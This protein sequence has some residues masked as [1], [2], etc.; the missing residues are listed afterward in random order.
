MHLSDVYRCIIQICNFGK[1]QKLIFYAICPLLRLSH[2][3]FISC[4]TMFS[5]PCGWSWCINLINCGWYLSKVINALVRSNGQFFYDFTFTVKGRW[6]VKYYT[7]SVF[8][9]T[10]TRI[11]MK[12]YRK[13]IPNVLSQ[14]LSFRA[15]FR[16]RPHRS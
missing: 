6:V 9:K 11:M 12:L 8:L 7:F 13:Q 4:N 3:P 14:V 5:L 2:F 16:V 1:N 15:G 10:A